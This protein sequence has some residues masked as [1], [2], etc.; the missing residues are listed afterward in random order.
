MP[1]SFY[2]LGAGR[3]G[4]GL[5]MALREAGATLAGVWNRGAAGRERVRALLGCQAE[6][7][8]TDGSPH[9]LA[10]ADWVFVCVRDAAVA[11]VGDLLRTSGLVRPGT[12]VA[13]TSGSV[14]ATV[15][16]AIPGARLGS[17]HPLV[18]CA[19]PAQA[20]RSLRGAAFALEGEPAAVSTMREV[21]ALLGGRSHS[22]SAADKPRY[23]A[24]LVM[25]SNLVLALVHQAVAE[26]QAAG[27][28]DRAAVLELAHGA[29]DIARSEG[30]V[31]A[32]TG[33]VVRGDAATVT[34]HLACLEGEAR[35]AYKA[36][37]AI[38]LRMA[39]Q[40]GLAEEEVQALRQ[41]LERA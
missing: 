28:A 29:L 5:A 36:L 10:R 20:A 34:G 8:E 4:L 19:T 13:H 26:A 33:P 2:V 35:A 37:S 21:V 23:H 24:A 12:L 9:Q 30:T 1:A 25:A 6:G 16:G 18:A 14:P 22:V 41:V 17:L 31:A 3:V 11:A 39:R 15:L 32:L 40:R 27:F 38:A 7:G